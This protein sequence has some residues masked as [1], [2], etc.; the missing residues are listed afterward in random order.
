MAAPS[1]HKRARVYV[2]YDETTGAGPECFWPAGYR[3]PGSS[4]DA[5]SF[6]SA[7]FESPTS[8]SEGAAGLMASPALTSLYVQH[9]QQQQQQHQQHPY[10]AHAGYPGKKSASPR[11]GWPSVSQLAHVAVSHRNWRFCRPD[12]DFARIRT[13]GASLHPLC[14]DTAMHITTSPALWGWR[15]ATRLRRGWTSGRAAGARARARAVGRLPVIISGYY[16]RL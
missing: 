10:M 15:V 12:A 1:A 2:L 9:M 7:G 14:G 5:L 6:A 11:R 4:S 16:H 3:V 8:A 13:F